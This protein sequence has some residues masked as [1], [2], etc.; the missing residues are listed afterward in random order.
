MGY[1]RR[2]VEID[3]AGRP[4][5]GVRVAPRGVVAEL[6]T[7]Q[8][9]RWWFAL[10][11]AAA[12]ALL[13]A[14]PTALIPNPVFDRE[15][16]PTVWAWPVLLVT[17]A[18]AGLVAATYVARRDSDGRERG[19]TLGAIGAATTFFAVGCPVCNKLVLL[20]IGY[21]GALQYFQPFQPYLAAGSIALLATALVMRLR[22][23]GSCPLPTRVAG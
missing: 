7:W 16:P 4:T 18:L 9:R 10:A 3:G 1:C 12:T 6:R 2:V 20:A 23:E 19:G 13:V 22:R 17:S 21:T 8:A 11:T 5:V 15:V 14:L